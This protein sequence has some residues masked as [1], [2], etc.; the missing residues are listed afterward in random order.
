MTIKQIHDFITFVLNKEISGYVS[1]SDIDKALDRAQMSKFVELVG[2]PKGYQPGR[3]IPP[4]AY[5]L[6][7]KISD[8]LRYFK[9]RQQ[10]TSTSSGIINLNAATEFNNLSVAPEYLHILGMYA[11]SSRSISS[12]SYSSSAGIISESISSSTKVINNPV[13]VVNEDQL[14]ERLISQLAEPT[15]TSPIAILGDGGNKIQLFPEAQISG[16]MMY[17]ERPIKPFFSFV[18]D[19]RKVIHNPSSTNALTHTAVNALTAQDGTSVAA[20]S[21]TSVAVSVE[22]NW[23]ADCIN[24]IISRALTVLG[25]HLEDQGVQQYSELKTQQGS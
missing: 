1:P 23:P 7:Q 19:G 24:D 11:T 3:P 2:N 6:T 17:L 21:T 12:S 4:I 8:D 14:A 13:K 22:L 18:V 20:G 15:N 5:G 10:Y 16:Q 9:R 25:V